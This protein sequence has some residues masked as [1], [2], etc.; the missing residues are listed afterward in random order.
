M[1]LIRGLLL[2]VCFGIYPLHVYSVVQETTQVFLNGIETSVYFNDGDTFRVL[3]GPL[4]GSSA[5]LVGFNSL[6]SYG[7]VHQWGDWTT[8]ELHE[9]SKQATANARQGTWHCSTDSSKDTYGRFLADCKDLALD[10][11]SK[12]L[13]HIMTVTSEPAEAYL[14]EAQQK[15]IANKVGF[16][17]KGT[18]DF[19]LTSAHSL[20]EF[21]PIEQ[22]KL[23]VLST[24]N[25]YDRFVSTT[26]GHSVVINHRNRYQRC[27]VVS[28]APVE[29]RGASTMVYV[30]FKYRF[31]RNRA[32]CLR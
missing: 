8:A 30:D 20:D 18:P 32:E 2:I 16:W 22:A 28:Y 25:S 26:D 7:P 17:S 21:S 29:Q 15:A 14:V 11:V 3:E 27:E 9:N 6:E 4:K 13:A 1:F 5:R 10:Q 23:N 24:K 19:I 31:G 12:G